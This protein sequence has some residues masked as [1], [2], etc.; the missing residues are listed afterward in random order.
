MLSVVAQCTRDRCV[1]A[2]SQ[3]SAVHHR[4]ESLTADRDGRTERPWSEWSTFRESWSEFVPSLGAT[5]AV[6]RSRRLE[7]LGG[8]LWRSSR[9][10]AGGCCN[11][12]RLAAGAYC[13]RSGDSFQRTSRSCSTE[14]LRLH[15]GVEGASLPSQQA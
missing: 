9:K 11:P 12:R 5:V 1:H 6:Q 13:W 8:A 10:Q 3:R 15:R 2:P 14:L 4:Q 7:R